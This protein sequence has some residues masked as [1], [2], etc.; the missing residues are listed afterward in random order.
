VPAVWELPSAP[1]KPAPGKPAPGEPGDPG[2][3]AEGIPGDPGIPSAPPG[4]PGVPGIPGRP[5]NGEGMGGTCV[6]LTE[7]LTSIPSSPF[8]V[9]SES[10]VEL[11]D[12][13]LLGGPPVGV[14][15]SRLPEED[16][17]DP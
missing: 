6:P 16:A 10:P 5:G 4:I 2:R 12:E 1:G 14:E 9:S 8:E 7:T 11:E 17:V 13:E 3:P 15:E